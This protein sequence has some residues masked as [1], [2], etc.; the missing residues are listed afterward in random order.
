[1]QLNLKYQKLDVYGNHVFICQKSNNEKVY[2]KV[3]NYKKKM[4]RLKLTTYLHICE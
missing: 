4:D 3:L 1:M 2:K